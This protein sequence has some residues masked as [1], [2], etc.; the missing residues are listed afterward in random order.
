MAANKQRVG[1]EDHVSGANDAFVVSSEEL[2]RWLADA[3]Q[4]GARKEDRERTQGRLGVLSAP[5]APVRQSR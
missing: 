3:V 1:P 5:L 2:A 4:V